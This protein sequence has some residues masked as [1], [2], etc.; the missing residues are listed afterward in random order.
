MPAQR[1]PYQDTSVPV[2][3]S[4]EQIRQMLRGAGARGIMM[5]EN[6]AEDESTEE[7]LLEFSW[8]VGEN[9]ESIQHVR[10]IVK[11]L[12]PEEGA[13]TAWRISPEQRERQAWRA[14]QWYLKTMLEAAEFRLL[15]FEDVFMSF[16]VANDGRTV[17]EHVM[18]MLESG[19][20]QLPKGD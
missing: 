15:R 11:P 12:P 17:G 3:R 16:I 9:F 14:L 5:I 2:E 6:W 13:R 4:K 8:P 18:P 20:L 1:S 10:L 7:C 19:R